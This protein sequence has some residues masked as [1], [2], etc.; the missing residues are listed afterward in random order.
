M[1]P[2]RSPSARLSR[3]RPPA[4]W[5]LP[6]LA[7]LVAVVAVSAPASAQ[8]SVRPVIHHYSPGSSATRIIT[9]RNDGDA[10]RQLRIEV[11]DFDRD[12]S[13]AHRFLAA[14]EH[15]RSCAQRMEVFPD[16]LHLEPGASADV[17]VA[18]DPGPRTCWSIVFAETV[19]G[20]RE[21][22][23][24]GRRIGAKIFG[25][26]PGASRRLVV[27][28]VTA[29]AGSDSVEVAFWVANRGGIPARPEGTVE[30]RTVSGEVV[31]RRELRPFGVLPGRVRRVR[32]SVAAELD[33]G[34]HLAVPILDGGGDHLVGGQ[35]AFR[36]PPEET[37]ARPP[38]ER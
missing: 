36:V 8:F 34:R 6:S 5:L 24:I 31:G 11:A 28:S 38:L 7:A 12:P 9:V 26:G 18:L 13:G 33:S 32:V 21:G 23:R 17:R 20:G 30:L 37:A 10:P 35:G 27:D 29:E 1:N 3:A 14:G 4:V 15:E 16:Q 25:H 19:E 22:I 2:I